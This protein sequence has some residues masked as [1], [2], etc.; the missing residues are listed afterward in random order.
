M[1]L[2]NRNWIVFGN[3]SQM[4]QFEVEGS[5]YEIC[6]C[7]SKIIRGNVFIIFSEAENINWDQ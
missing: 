4:E 1:F 3:T 7:D 5:S 2:L 6:Y